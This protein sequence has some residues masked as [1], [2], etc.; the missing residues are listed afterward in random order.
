MIQ[1]LIVQLVRTLVE[2]FEVGEEVGGE[3]EG[4]GMF[5]HIIAWEGVIG[6]SG[7]DMT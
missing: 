4:F 3:V 7:G 2:Y 1:I 5:H 6:R